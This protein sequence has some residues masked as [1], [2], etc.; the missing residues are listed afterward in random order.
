MFE[1]GSDEYRAF[2]CEKKSMQETDQ[3]KFFKNFDEVVQGAILSQLV[4]QPGEI[5]VVAQFETK[6]WV[7]VTSMRV[8]WKA[9]ETLNDLGYAQIRTMGWS[10]G[11][12]AAKTRRDPS[13]VELKWINDDNE[14]ENTKGRSPWFFIF[15][16]FGNRHELFMHPGELIEIWNVILFLRGLDRVYSLF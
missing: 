16:S 13:E 9:G 1:T 6:N 10:A 4:L 8:I 12:K 7:L 14:I 11:P 3:F 2:R 5:P 15:D